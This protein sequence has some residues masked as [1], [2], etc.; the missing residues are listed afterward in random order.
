MG[1]HR[2]A[3]EACDNFGLDFDGAYQYVAARNRGLKIAA[4]D[5]DFETCKIDFL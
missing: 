1:S 5:E 4:M 3:A 2:D